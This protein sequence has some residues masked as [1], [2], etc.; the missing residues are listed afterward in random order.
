MT[1]FF[2]APKVP[3]RSFS[4]SIITLLAAT[5]LSVP[6][7]CAAQPSGPESDWERARSVLQD[8]T[9]GNINAAIDRWETL[10]KSGNYS[11]EEYASF[12]V[13]YPDWP[14]ESRFRRNAEQAINMESYSPTQVLAYFDRFPPVTNT[15]RARYAVALNTAGQRDKAVEVAREAWRNGT[16]TEPDEARMLG[17]FSSEFTVA[18]HDARMDALLWANAASRANAQLSFVSP[19]KRPVYA[20]RLNMIRKQPVN[21][22][23]LPDSVRSDPGYL[24]AYATRLR[25]SGNSITSRNLLANRPKLA[26]YPLD[27]EEWYE[28]LLVNAR[29]AA[30]DSQWTLA[31]N[32]ASKVDDAFPEGTDISQENLGVRDDYTSLTW[33]AGT[34]ALQK[35]RQPAK[36][37]GMFARYG[38]AAQTPQTRS[39][40]FYW[41]GKAAAE[42]GDT[43][44]A[45]KYF[46]MAAQYDDHFYGQ[47]AVERLGREVGPFAT[48]AP[49]DRVNMTD[50]GQ[51]NSDRLVQAAKLATRRSGDWRVHNSFFR[52]LSARAESESDFLLL[53]EL[54]KEI[55]RRDLAVIAGQSARKQGIDRLQAI[56][57]PDMPVPGGY[58][59]N[60]TFIHAI[61]R[62]ES[63]FSQRAVSHAK[64]RGLMQLLPSTAREQA[65]KI[66]MAYNFGSLT[67]DPLYNI[68]LGS[69]YFERM[70]RYYGGSYP[71]AA[72]AYNAGPGNVNKWLRRNGDPR[73]GAIGIIEWIEKIPIFETKN[74]VQ[75]VMENAVV[76]DVMHPD[77][78]GYNGPNRLSHYLGKRTPG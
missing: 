23:S 39:K 33:L 57:F 13:N 15:G 73:T 5:A 9:S 55:G 54:S 31:Y 34:T 62:Q 10:R 76:Y 43:A 29:A 70:R 69:S 19:Q 8:R 78:A 50:R 2:P 44:Q 42:A 3:A 12:L 45:E 28:T 32:I 20:A 64:A 14:Y 51:F 24:T 41:A 71:L 7:A 52:A 17:L 25:A 26:S 58:Q 11:F 77:K 27:A 4:R 36:A 22:A 67:E 47:L 72:A 66:G 74:Y 56:A 63:Q 21:H 6:M 16:M 75:R 40:G 60:W 46:S 1:S 65:G 61:T 37:V 49:S 30:N 48:S 68:R 38:N 53:G 59:N 18:D 35:Q